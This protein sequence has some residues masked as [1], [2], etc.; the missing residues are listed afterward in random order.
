MKKKEKKTSYNVFHA[1]R[2]Y[3]KLIEQTR[4]MYSIINPE[5]IKKFNIPND[6]SE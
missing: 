1:S 5:V 3:N 6:K 4:I 2:I